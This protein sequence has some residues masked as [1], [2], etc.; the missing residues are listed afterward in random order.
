MIDHIMK[1]LKSIVKLCGYFFLILLI[2]VCIVFGVA[3]VLPKRK[4]KFATEIKKESVEKKE[5][6]AGKVFQFRAGV[7]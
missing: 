1:R 4:E 3:P 2:S 5:D 6:P 7:K